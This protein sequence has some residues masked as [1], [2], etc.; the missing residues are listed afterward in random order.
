MKNVNNT[1][2]PLAMRNNVIKQAVSDHRFGTIMNIRSM[3][4][5]LGS[6]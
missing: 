3:S 1:R 5:F 2:D 4:R 6:A